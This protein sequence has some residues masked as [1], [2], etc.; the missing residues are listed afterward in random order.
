MTRST[1]PD[2]PIFLVGFMGSGKTTVGRLLAARLGWAFADL[3]DRIVA[4]AGMLI[5]EI[6]AREGEPAFRRREADALRAAAAERRVVLATGGGAACRDENLTLMLGAGHV[7]ALAVSA[8]EAVRRAG[9]T[10][11]RPLLDGAADPGAAAAALLAAREPFYAQA[12]LRVETDGRAPA[13]VADE[14][15]VWLAAPGPAHW[16][17]RETA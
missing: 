2:A 14:I 13:Q 16:P 17:H 4:A 12:H 1:E 5:P 15:A 6:F 9:R 8:A 10:S 11:G 7:V 3:D